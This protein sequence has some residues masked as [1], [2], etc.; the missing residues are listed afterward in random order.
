[1]NQNLLDALSNGSL[2]FILTWGF[3]VITFHLARAEDFAHKKRIRIAA[4]TLS[5][6]ASA[7]FI[8]TIFFLLY[9][10][11]LFIANV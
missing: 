11:I 7:C 9:I 4:Y 6:L 5:F 3:G 8:G 10:V 1:M 2:L